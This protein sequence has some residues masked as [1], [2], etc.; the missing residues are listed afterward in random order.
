MFH[1]I[2]AGHFAKSI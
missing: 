2:F 1:Y